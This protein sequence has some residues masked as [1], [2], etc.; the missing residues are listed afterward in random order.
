VA[1]AA[2]VAIVLLAS[3]WLAARRH[4]P[5]TALAVVAAAGM[6]AVPIVVR[7]VPGRRFPSYLFM[8][9][10]L[11]T[12]ASLLVAGTELLARAPRLRAQRWLAG[13]LLLAV[14]AL[15]L[16][17]GI[18]EQR[19]WGSFQRDPRSV[20]IE[21]LTQEIRAQVGADLPHNRRFLL[22]IAP[23]EDQFTAMGLILALDK[24]GLRFAVEPFGSPRVEG[25]FTPR[26]DEWAELLVG[27]LP[28]TEGARRL[29][30]PDGLS[31]VWQLPWRAG[32][33]APGH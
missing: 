27:N 23:H 33:T 4:A 24:A 26:G 19:A 3:G 17:N 25:R 8:W 9:A 12:L 1:Q 7:Y 11:V 16:A 28:A 32:P 6:A 13:L 21:R 5:T 22:R 2:L 20:E 18:R 30:S 14:P 15:L 29:G 10:A 31:V